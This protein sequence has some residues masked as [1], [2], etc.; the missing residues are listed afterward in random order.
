M[1][2]PSDERKRHHRAEEKK[3]IGGRTENAEELMNMG[4]TEFLDELGRLAPES[5]LV[6][7]YRAAGNLRL[8]RAI[9]ELVRRLKGASAES[10]SVARSLRDLTFVVAFATLMTAAG[11]LYSFGL[12]WPVCSDLSFYTIYLNHIKRI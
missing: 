7:R 8:V 5:V 1:G 9:H 6:E 12:R 3:Q 2:H 10:T 4:D 11:A